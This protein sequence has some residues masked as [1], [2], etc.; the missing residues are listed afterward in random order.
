LFIALGGRRK[1][2]YRRIGHLDNGN[3]LPVEP[4]IALA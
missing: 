2:E 1:L 4:H 3:Q